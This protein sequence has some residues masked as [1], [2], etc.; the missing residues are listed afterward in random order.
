MDVS[1]LGVVTQ[2]KKSW[3]SLSESIP[4]AGARLM[5]VLTPRFSA[6]DFVLIN[7]RQLIPMSSVPDIVQ[8]MQSEE[9]KL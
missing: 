7:Y 3:R 4:S 8:Y 6:F 5:S 9:N 2:H 1:S